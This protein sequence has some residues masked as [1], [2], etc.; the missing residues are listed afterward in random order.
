MADNWLGSHCRVQLALYFL[1]RG[2][3]TYSDDGATT[4]GRRV[5][6]TADDVLAGEEPVAPAEA[7]HMVQGLQEQHGSLGVLDA[8]FLNTDL[9]GLLADVGQELAVRTRAVG[10]EFVKNLCQGSGG[11]GDLAE[12]IE[13][14]NL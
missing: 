12:V 10:T 13:E 14:G 11:H 6:S 2:Q 7:A 1:V 4:S 3:S 8:V 5:G 9:L